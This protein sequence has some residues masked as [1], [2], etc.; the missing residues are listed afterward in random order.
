M[1]N[2]GSDTALQRRGTFQTFKQGFVRA[3]Q[4]AMDLKYSDLE[5]RREDS[6]CRSP[7]S[8]ASAIVL[9]DSALEKS[10]R[11]L[12][13]LSGLCLPDEFEALN[14]VPNSSNEEISPELDVVSA[15]SEPVSPGLSPRWTKTAEVPVEFLTM[16]VDLWELT[17]EKAGPSS[18]RQRHAAMTPVCHSSEPVLS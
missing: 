16:L 5:F 17:Q 2:A 6:D 10:Q 1:N 14:D 13:S 7:Q 12:E 18:R 8:T 4:R 3:E 9:T 11:L 15:P